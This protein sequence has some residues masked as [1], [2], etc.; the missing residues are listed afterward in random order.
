VRL[1]SEREFIAERCAMI[2]IEFVTRRVATGSFLKRNH[3]VKE[4]FRFSPV[5]SEYFYKVCRAFSGCFYA[6]WLQVL[7]KNGTIGKV[8]INGTLM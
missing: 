5:K 4:G 3:N 7:G 1:E 6:C 2:P 8:G